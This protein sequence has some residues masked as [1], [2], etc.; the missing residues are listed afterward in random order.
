[1]ATFKGNCPCC[2]AQ[3]A[4]FTTQIMNRHA[5]DAAYYSTSQCGVCLRPVL[6]KLKASG[7][8]Q[9]YSAQFAGI[10]DMLRTEGFVI[11]GNTFALS[12]LDTYSPPILGALAPPLTSEVGLR[13]EILG[14]TN[15]PEPR[16]KRPPAGEPG[17]RFR[18]ID[19]LPRHFPWHRRPMIGGLLARRKR[20]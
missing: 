10:P 3:S 16:V 18:W 5:R 6:F 2:G 14:P 11:G 19:A 4:T 17:A 1:M 13:L 7:P 20:C 12:V 15:S 9:D 8:Q